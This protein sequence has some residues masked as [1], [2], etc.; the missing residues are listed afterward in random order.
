MNQEQ[1]QNKPSY[2]HEIKD[3]VPGSNNQHEITKGRKT[4]SWDRG[5][6]GH[7]PENYN[8]FSSDES[9]SGSD[10]GEFIENDCADNADFFINNETETEVEGINGIKEK[11]I[12]S[13][14]EFSD[15]DED[16]SEYNSPSDTD[17]NGYDANAGSNNVED[18]YVKNPQYDTDEDDSE[19]YPPSN[20][21]DDEDDSDYYPTSDTNDDE[22]DYDYYPPSDT[23]DEDDT[24]DNYSDDIDG[25]K[26]P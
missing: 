3:W 9:D 19:Y 2:Y 21:N 18:N 23:N 10:L 12:T 11:I 22:D 13:G 20:T 8:D 25:K 5:F 24:Y 14:D 26:L 16:D 6:N 1:I 7:L 15:T 4:D 17:E